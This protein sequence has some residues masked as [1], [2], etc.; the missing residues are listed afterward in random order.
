MTWWVVSALLLSAAGC[1]AVPRP[2]PA[3]LWAGARIFGLAV[4]GALG[5]ALIV[6]SVVG[7]PAVVAVGALTAAAAPWLLVRHRR[8]VATA[9]Q[10]AA[11]PDAIEVIRAGV[12]SGATLVEAVADGAERGPDV[13]RSRFRRFR[14]S[15]VAGAPFQRAIGM[16]R[17]P[18]DDVSDRVAA[19]LVLA[20]EVGSCDVG[21]VLGETA[22]FLRADLAQQREIDARRSWNVAAA[23]MAVAAPW[24]TVAV[25]S[26]QPS[27]RAAYSSATGTV[28]L[29][30][31]AAATSVAYWLMT[32]IGHSGTGQS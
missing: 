24:V 22:D 1:L 23:R 15:M 11:W 2:E 3:R 19:V 20:H 5:A 14:H 32:R 12:R 18:G 16:L 7:V 30:V 4:S 25:L 13:L 8:Q 26:I 6:D 21:R 27:G 31:V 17:R 29:A 9:E 10:R 28:L